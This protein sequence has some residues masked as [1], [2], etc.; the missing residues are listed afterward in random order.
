M[1]KAS[2]K[3]CMVVYENYWTDPRVR[4]EAEA[5]AESGYPVYVLCL[6]GL[7][8]KSKA[9][10]GIV[11]KELPV[12]KYSGH[13]KLMYIFT[14]IYFFVL[15]L[16]YVFFL[17]LK[18]RFQLVWVHNPPDALIFVALFPKLLG[19]KVILD[20]HDLTPELYISKFR[21]PGF[22]FKALLV[23]EK[24]ALRLANHVFT[25]NSLF[26]KKLLD[27]TGISS[28]K[29][30]VIVNSPDSKFFDGIRNDNGDERFLLVNHGTIAYRYGLDIA[31]RAV[32]LVKERI[33]EICFEIYGRGEERSELERLVDKLGLKEKVIFKGYIDYAEIPKYLARADIAVVPLRRDEHTNLAFPTKVFE[34][35]HLGIPVIA[36]ETKIIR[37]TFPKD[38]IMFFKP[39]D[40]RDLA[41]CILQVYNNKDLKDKLIKNSQKFYEVHRWEK[42]KK[43]LLYEVERVM[44]T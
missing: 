3:I 26:R 22:L 24:I 43:K 15:S 16:F 32:A 10:N 34:Y 23:F 29:I 37:S 42:V 31:I 17:H 1:G 13:S 27:R 28:S 9:P 21:V 19:T 25:A 18:Q 11:V 8:G 20:V 39:E 38:A 36:S 44:K 2:K 33:P 12:S 6:K 4:R 7:H 14:Y 30:T 35:V 40:E 41:K 5:L